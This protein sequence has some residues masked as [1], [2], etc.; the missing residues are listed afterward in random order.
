MSAHD[1]VYEYGKGQ[2]SGRPEYY[3]GRGNNPGD[4]N[5]DHLEMIYRGVKIEHNAGAAKSFVNLVN[6]L[7]PDASATTFLLSYY[8]L[9][10]ADWKYRPGLVP[11]SAVDS[12][13]EAIADANRKDPR[14][15]YAA[16]MAGMMGLLAGG[17]RDNLYP[18]SMITGKFLANHRNELGYPK[19]EPQSVV[20]TPK[21]VALPR[22]IPMPELPIDPPSSEPVADRGGRRATVFAA[23]GGAALLAAGGISTFLHSK[24][25]SAPV[26]P[27]PAPTAQPASIAKAPAQET[28]P[29]SAASTKPDLK[30]VI[31]SEIDNGAFD[32][33]PTLHHHHI[34]QDLVRALAHDDWRHAAARIADAGYW[35]F[36]HAGHTTTSR[37]AGAKL[38]GIAG[39]VVDQN[40]LHNPNAESIR[41]SVHWIGNL[42]YGAALPK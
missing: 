22:P 15:A 14:A 2:L 28:A 33:L 10:R 37:M 29:A 3:S 18:A 35:K 5:S 12:F 17:G 38:Y 25:E 34:K 30:A 7:N 24:H 11:G 8:H 23:I 1:I 32:K 26:Q 19:E 16:G 20:E 27:T 21:P 6:D 4:L 13:A 42:K 40:N 41:H 36:N 39:Q 9:E 31:Q